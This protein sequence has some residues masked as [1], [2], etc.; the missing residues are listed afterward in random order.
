MRPLV[1]ESADRLKP[2]NPPPEDRI[3]ISLDS[4][5][6]NFVMKTYAIGERN[7][8][9]VERNASWQCDTL[10]RSF[11]ERHRMSYGRWKIG[12]TDNTAE[13]LYH[14]WPSNQLIW[15]QDAYMA[16][17]YL[18]ATRLRQGIN[19][20]NIARFRQNDLLPCNDHDLH[21]RN[22]LAR[23][24][25][26]ALCNSYDAEGYGLFMEQGTG[27][28]AIVIARIC[29]E[30]KKHR[31]ETGKPYMA[32]IVCPKQL[33]FNWEL[34]FQKFATSKGRFTRIAGTELQR[35]K[36]TIDAVKVAADDM[37]CVVCVSYESLRLTP[38]LMMIPWDLAVADESHYGKT[39]SAKRTKA[40]L[41]LRD[42]SRQRMVLTGTPV[43]NTVF[44]LYTQFEFLGA[45]WSGFTS[46]EAFKRFYG[47]F[48]QRRNQNGDEGFERM[49]G[50]QNLPFLKERIARTTYVIRK[51]EALPDLPDKVYDVCEVE[52]SK[53]QKEC[54]ANVATKLVHEIEDEM[55][56]SGMAKQ[57]IAQNILTKLL[58]L[59]QITSGFVVFSEI[60]DD[61]GNII[62]PKSIDRFDPNPKLEELVEIL[63]AK[64]R[65]DKTIVWACFV[66]DIRSI[67]SRLA[68]EG[69][70]AVSF[71]GGTSDDDRETA[72]RRFNEDPH[73]KVFVGNASAGGTGL[74]L[75]GYPPGSEHAD[76]YD[77]NANHVIYY[78][79]NWSMPARAQSEDRCHRRGTRTHVQI[80]DLVV[81]HSIDDE[82]RKRVTGK[83][84]VANIVSDVKQILRNVFERNF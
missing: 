13:I 59:A 27:K 36:Q 18:V 10:M 44:D 29:N 62:Q 42:L 52:M 33:R 34:E 58:K 56:G 7:G 37:F 60:Y 46:F 8:Q 32:I 54:Y 66:Q 16:Y 35:I 38:S 82:I 78:S 2:I 11:P 80:T 43:T 21:P 22:T 4:E 51:A 63:K 81:P 65:N 24:Q 30:A 83:I 47:V 48:E 72:V 1:K 73:C 77:T 20:E 76:L 23:Y 69:I 61:D 6:K 53:E 31:E 39:P 28:T 49:I 15:Q 84:D 55:A 5:A 68:M 26:L 67:M 71:Y 57:V 70:D 14:R 41:E 75:L 79:Q 74:T 3:D 17:Q 45:G 12:A 9:Y 25:Q 50:V 40:L 19:A 64:G